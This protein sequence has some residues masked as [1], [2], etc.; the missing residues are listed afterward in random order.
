VSG[1]YAMIKAAV[2]VGAGDRDALVLETLMSFKRAG[3]SGV[4]TYHA[5]HAA[6]LMG[7]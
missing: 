2:A 7:A 6:R 5:L 1:E 4:L 3:A